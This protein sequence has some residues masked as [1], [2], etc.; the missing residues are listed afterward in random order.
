[1]ISD[2]DSFY[3]NINTEHAI[4]TLEKLFKL[5]EDELP[6]GFPVKLILLGTKRL[7]E[8][9]VF[10]F[11]SRF[12]VQTNGTAM[13]TNVACMYAMIYYSYYEET[14]LR[15]L[16]YNKFYRRLIDDSLIIVDADTSWEHL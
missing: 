12:F 9:N 10:T 8:N 6:K 14:K 15:F 2:A 16:P 1:M 5:H 11:G 4:E 7:M 3:T 13:G